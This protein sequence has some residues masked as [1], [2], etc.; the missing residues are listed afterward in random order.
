[1]LCLLEGLSCKA[2]QLQPGISACSECGP[3]L[4]SAVPARH[5]VSWLSYLCQ[6]PLWGGQYYI[7]AGASP[8]SIF[9]TKKTNLRDFR[10]SAFSKIGVLG[11][12]VAAVSTVQGQIGPLLLTCGGLC[13]SC[14]GSGSAAS[15]QEILWARWTQKCGKKSSTET[16]WKAS[17]ATTV[18]TCAVT[19]QNGVTFKLC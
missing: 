18:V 6:G 10:L 12:C 14:L 3:R 16:V 17:A 2:L 1:M 5:G 9:L 15:G 11:L 8:P 19:R 7:S 13:H 4:K